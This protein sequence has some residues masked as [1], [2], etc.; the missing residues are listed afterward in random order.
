MIL[1]PGDRVILG[2]DPTTALTVAEA[3]YCGRQVQII[4]ATGR[5]VW[6][7]VDRIVPAPEPSTWHR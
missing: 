5:T 1:I 7:R 3:Y 4:T 6:A 2:Q